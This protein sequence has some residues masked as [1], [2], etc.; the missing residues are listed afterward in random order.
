[1]TIH[2]EP[3]LPRFLAA[4]PPRPPAGRPADPLE[5]RLPPR[6]A[7]RAR[8]T[9]G[10]PAGGFAG[11]PPA[12]LP[13]TPFD[14]A[15]LDGNQDG[16]LSGSEVPAALQPY[17]QQAADGRR[18]VTRASLAGGPGATPLAGPGPAP[19]VGPAP[20]PAYGPLPT[21]GPPPLPPAPPP[22]PIPPPPAPPVPGPAPVPWS[23]PVPLP[24]PAPGPAPSPIA[25]PGG[26]SL[27]DFE[28][29]VGFIQFAPQKNASVDGVLGDIE[30]HLP[31]R[32]GSTY[33][34]SDPVTWGHETTH[35]INSHLRNT[36]EYNPEGAKVNG[37]YVGNDKAVVLQEPPITKSSVGRYVPDSLKG[38]RFSMYVTGQ[39]A[40]EREPLYLMD[41]WVAYS[42]GAA[43]GVDLA[44]AGKW[45]DGGRDAVAGVVEFTAYGFAM[46]MAIEAQ[47]PGY[48]AQH[49][50][51]KNFIAWQGLRG[52]DLFREGLKVPAFAGFPE[53]HKQLERLRSA[54]D[55]E[56]LR[57]FIRTQYG[58][59]YLQRL[60]QA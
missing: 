44:K 53:Q 5:P 3:P 60:L 26:T 15:A 25:G 36:Q 58:D 42:N 27:A 39:R 52:M 9:A 33:R 14:F 51:L 23:G 2:A 41:E 47:Q 38:S 46:A 59:A 19:V 22:P 43:V 40:F 6:G 49:P 55:A 32:Y 8:L 35:G 7:D 48:L 10:D 31:S 54:P 28:A 29:G 34:D 17:A 24:A 50:K 11:L 18:I 57:A 1:M 37:F 12:P 30:R 56:P 16:Y 20:V 21:P 13:G 4:T 45:R